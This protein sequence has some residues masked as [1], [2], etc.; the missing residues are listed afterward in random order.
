MAKGTSHQARGDGSK[1]SQRCSQGSLWTLGPGSGSERGQKQDS[2]LIFKGGAT[3]TPFHQPGLTSWRV[4]TSPK[5]HQWLVTTS[6]I[7]WVCRDSFCSETKATVTCQIVYL[8]EKKTERVISLPQRETESLNAIVTD[9]LIYPSNVYI[10]YRLLLRS[11]YN[12]TLVWIELSISY[13]LLL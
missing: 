11:N 10:L 3:E 7:A 12:I 4:K 9:D 13:K 8:H 2:N 6:S 1:S 5:Q